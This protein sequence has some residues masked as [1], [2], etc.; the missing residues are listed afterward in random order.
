MT[1]YEHSVEIN[2][3]KL[4]LQVGKLAQA[5]DSSVLARLG[6]T[7][8]LVTVAVG[9]ERT[10]L[11]YFP[12][13]VEYVEKL[14][15]GGIIKG[16]RW[17]KRE[18]KP[19]DESILKGRIVDRS[20]RPLFPKSFRRDVQV[21]MTVLSVDKVHSAEIV[22][23]IAASAALH[24]SSVPWKGPIGLMRIGAISLSPLNLVINPT[25]EHQLQTPLLDLVVAST[26]QKVLMI[27]T[28]AVEVSEEIL[29]QGIKEAKRVNSNIIQVIEELR[30]KVGKPKLAF[31]EKTD[32]D[33]KEIILNNY[34]TDIKDFITKKLD[35]E[36][37]NYEALNAFVDKVANEHSEIEDKTLIVKA[38]D[39]A[40]KTYIHNETLE[41]GV[42]VDGRDTKTIRP[43]SAEVALLPRVHGTGLFNRGATQA[44]SIATL[45]APDNSQI[46]EEPEGQENK[47]YIHHYNMPPYTV[48][49]TGRI[50]S[51]S[52]R[53]IGHGALAEKAVEVMLPSL[54]EFPYTIRVVTE[55]LSS[56][57][58]TSM[59]STCASCLALMDAGVPIKKIV[60]GIAMGLVAENDSKY[61]I[62][63]DIMGI[64]DFSGLMDF[65]V[66]GTRDGITA[67]QLDVKNDGLTDEMI[68]E[69]LTDAKTARMQVINVM[70]NALAKP[71]EQVS[72]FAPKVAVLYPPAD[73]IGEIIGPGGKNIRNLQSTTGTVI[74]I[75]DNGVV[76]ISGTDMTAVE[77]AKEMIKSIYR[78]LKSGE[79]FTGKVIK[80]FPFGA[81]VEFLGNKEGLIHVSQMGRGYVKQASDVLHEDDEV[82]IK[83]LKQEEGKVSL[84]L[85]KIFGEEKEEN[86]Q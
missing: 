42:R 31:D 4:T 53:E 23:S 6:D 70:E 38:I 24:I 12:L 28:K 75:D 46:I 54:E 43:L 32:K 61:R 64:E 51:P 37:E 13:S 59:A 21:V 29:E 8:V 76:S 84:A 67:I 11:D 47:R 10:D 22:A 82:Q 71:R 77:K 55:I 62:L 74:G 48:G 1:Q 39:S 81:V 33:L 57:G 26:Q 79:V 17:V 44:L 56:N 27:E 65:K 14:Y 60:G 50:G 49:E 41:T 69:T 19:T 40:Y 20:I 18:G 3:E 2:G 16:S 25:E 80:L 78:E 86:T 85:L 73:K 72:E 66:A 34:K 45:G 83:F 7:T 36:G 30:Q 68:H 52:R 63:T 58:S 35:K 5:C 9:K 15:A